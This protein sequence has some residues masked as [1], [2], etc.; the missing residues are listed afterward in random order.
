MYGWDERYAELTLPD[1]L[2]L[3]KSHLP[4]A[5]KGVYATKCFPKGTV[6]GPYAGIPLTMLEQECQEE[7]GYGWEVKRRCVMHFY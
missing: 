1:G 5:G 2:V 4:F 3:T 7:S 6:F